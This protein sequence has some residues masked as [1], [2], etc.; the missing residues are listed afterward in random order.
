V[1]GPSP[2]RWIIYDNERTTTSLSFE[3]ILES[4]DRFVEW[5]RQE[6]PSVSSKCKTKAAGIDTQM[7]NELKLLKV[8][9][10]LRRCGHGG[11][12]QVSSSLPTLLSHPF[13]FSPSLPLIVDLCGDG[14][15]ERTYLLP[16]LKADRTQQLLQCDDSFEWRVLSPRLHS[17]G[18]LGRG[19]PLQRLL[20]RLSLARARGQEGGEL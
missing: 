20:C 6:D 17:R 9:K 4:G 5:V 11:H 2:L 16:T 13:L 12:T 3:K 14:S 15:N 19:L 10:R 1:L 7:K 8:Q 18:L